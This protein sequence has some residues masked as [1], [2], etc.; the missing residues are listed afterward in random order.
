[1]AVA[2]T[3]FDEEKE[4]ILDPTIGELAFK[5]YKWGVKDG[6][7]YVNQNR[8]ESQHYCTPEE[9]GLGDPKDSKFFK[10]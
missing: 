9:L 5:E 1:M 4:P 8:I 10:I 3:A 6:V 7:P 2:F